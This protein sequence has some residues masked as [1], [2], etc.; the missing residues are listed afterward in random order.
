LS[1]EFEQQDWVK[2]GVAAALSRQYAA[3]QRTFLVSLAKMLETALPEDT[4]VKYRGGFFS[5]KTIQRITLKLGD[6]NY[7]IEDPGSGRLA[8][9]RTHVVRGI[10]LK[11]EPIPVEEW[12]AE[13]GAA[14]DERA[15][16]SAA[17]R[18]ALAKL[19]G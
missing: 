1:D 2:F 3:D 17:A 6:T 14:I 15:A 8:A 16:Q 13:I 19:L 5:A 7:A 18:N 12:V 10:T 11:T 4:E 9:L